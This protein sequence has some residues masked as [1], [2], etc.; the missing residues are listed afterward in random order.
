MHLA[1]RIAAILVIL[2]SIVPAYAASSGAR[3]DP[4]AIAVIQAA[5]AAMGGDAAVQGIKDSVVTGTIAPTNGSLTR[6]ASF[7]WKTLGTEFR[8]E[9]T[10]ELNRH[11]FVS[12]HGKPAVSRNGHVRPV[13]YH[14][15]EGC[16]SFHLAA[17]MLSGKLADPSYSLLDAG[18]RSISG[19]TAVA[20]Q[21]HANDSDPIATLTLQTWYFDATTALPLRVEYRVPEGTNALDLMN[22]AMEFADYRQTGIMAVPQSMTYSEE[23]VP[24]QVFSISTVDFNVGLDPSEFDL[25]GGVQ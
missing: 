18:Q 9:T 22:S 19:K 15:A 5:I 24:L 6:P 11:I 13:F 8:Y 14:V 10:R 12:G 21:T 2:P 23:G 7:T 3:R 1:S 25:Q 20:V 17:L 4:S 16:P